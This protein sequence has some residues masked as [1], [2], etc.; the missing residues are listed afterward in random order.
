MSNATHDDVVRLFPGTQ[1][2]AVLEILATEASVKELEAA[3]SL[4]QNDDEGLIDIKQ[5]KGGRL[6]QLLGILAKSEIR[7]RNDRD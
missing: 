4:L 1:D 6:N 5:Q 7:P 3:L 2:H